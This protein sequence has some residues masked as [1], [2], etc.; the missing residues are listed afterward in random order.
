MVIVPVLV[1]VIIFNNANSNNVKLLSITFKETNRLPH[2]RLWV[3]IK[4]SES[5]L[6]N[7]QYNLLHVRIIVS[8]ACRLVSPLF[9]EDNQHKKS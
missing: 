2:V 8:T 4:F 5:R 6:H 3:H 1:T 9:I 7:Q